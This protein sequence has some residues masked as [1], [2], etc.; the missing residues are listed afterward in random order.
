MTTDRAIRVSI[1]SADPGWLLQLSEALS[2]FETFTY[3]STAAA[4]AQ[5]THGDA[6][7]VV[8]G[9]SE[10]DA[11]IAQPSE[12]TPDAAVILV[13]EQATV[14]LLRRAMNAGIA[15]VVEAHRIADLPAA[16]RAQRERIIRLAPPPD[17]LPS[18]PGHGHVV[19]V[20]SPKAGQGSTTVAVNLAVT[21]ARRGRVALVEGDPQFGDVLSAFGYRQ[22]RTE[23]VAAE[24]VV[25]DHWLGRFL[26]RHPTG[27]LLAIPRPDTTPENFQPEHALDAL[28]ALQ[29]QVDTVILDIPLW[30]LERY[31]LHR[32]ADEVLLVTTDRVRDLGHVRSAVREMGH[33][34]KN[35]SLVISNYVDGRT[36]KRAEMQTI[37]GLRT[38]GRIPETAEA[39]AALVKGEPLVAARPKGPEAAAF[40]ELADALAEVLATGAAPAS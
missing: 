2:D 30:A 4:V 32:T 9:P 13:V 10:A 26:Y 25:G 6:G 3:Q 16:V 1:V 38:L 18:A 24:D 5:I 34:E 14:D 22:S 28:T 29:S 23:L 40:G 15:D 37:T 36:P 39:D 27:V 11:F 35:T 33:H 17:D 20:T 8:V 7:I 12:E 21:L 31:R 19:V